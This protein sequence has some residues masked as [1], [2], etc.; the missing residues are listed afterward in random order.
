MKTYR[1][2]PP[3][4]SYDAIGAK[5]TENREE[6]LLGPSD[7]EYSSPFQMI[8]GYLNPQNWHTRNDTLVGVGAYLVIYFI[9][10]RVIFRP[11]RIAA[12]I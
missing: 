3:G 12:G 11:K 5:I 6:H 4:V 8:W 1:T 9:A 2:I 10:D 7:F